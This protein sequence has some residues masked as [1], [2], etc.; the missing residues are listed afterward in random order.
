MASVASREAPHAL[1]I[2]I[3]KFQVSFFHYGTSS[4]H[5]QFRCY[6]TLWASSRSPR[7][8]RLLIYI[9]R[10]TLSLWGFIKFSPVFLVWMLFHYCWRAVRRRMKALKPA[11]NT[12]RLESGKMAADTKGAPEMAITNEQRP[13]SVA[14]ST[15]A[16][17]TRASRSM[18]TACNS[19]LLLPQFLPQPR[20]VNIII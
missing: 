3:Y 6:L 20:F 16:F 11:R 17:L 4:P 1:F 9:P 12:A 5:L 10:K 18:A 2:L 13:A 14:R 7:K 19:L 8:K 15:P